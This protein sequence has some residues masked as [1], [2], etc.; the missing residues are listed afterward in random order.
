M[1]KLF[2][3]DEL[4]VPQP[5]DFENMLNNRA[6][7]VLVGYF[8]FSLKILRCIIR[9]KTYFCLQTFKTYEGIRES[10]WDINSL[11]ANIS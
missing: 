6:P 8:I 10:I 2:E 9:E 3:D 1:N 7:Y 4:H 11:L 5:S